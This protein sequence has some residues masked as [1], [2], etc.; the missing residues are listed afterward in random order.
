VSVLPHNL[1]HQTNL[2]FFP[3]SVRAKIRDE[4]DGHSASDSFW[5]RCLYEGERGDPLNV[6][7]GFLKSTILVKASTPHRAWVCGLLIPHC[8]GLSSDLYITLIR[9]RGPRCRIGPRGIGPCRTG[10][11]VST[12]TQKNTPKAAERCYR[13][14]DG[15]AGN[16]TVHCLC[17]CASTLFPSPLC[18][19][20]ILV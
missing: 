3:I 11:Q 9:R 5:L 16:R 14:Q 13:T 6:E 1:G 20:H 19:A 15:W 7:E 12:E 4:V 17:G 10:L 2:S 8:T 18:L